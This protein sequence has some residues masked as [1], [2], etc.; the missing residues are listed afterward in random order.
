[1]TS[2]RPWPNGIKSFSPD[3]T[4]LFNLGGLFINFN[5]KTWLVH[6]LCSLLLCVNCSATTTGDIE[7]SRL[8]SE[9]YESYVYAQLQQNTPLSWRSGSDS[10]SSNLWFIF[11]DRYIMAT[12]N[13]LY[14]VKLLNNRT[15]LDL[16]MKDDSTCAVNTVHTQVPVE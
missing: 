3:C 14:S 7:Q 11:N 15:R 13:K 10:F 9:T 4:H 16:R 5:K 2:T 8:D 6:I 1:M 12:P